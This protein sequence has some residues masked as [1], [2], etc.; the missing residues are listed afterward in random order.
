M[1]ATDRE[2]RFADCVARLV[3]DLLSRRC[4][5]PFCIRAARVVVELASR[6]G[7]DAGAIS[8]GVVAGGTDYRDWM[9]ARTGDDRT[10]DPSGLSVVVAPAPNPKPGRWGGHVVVRVGACLLVDAAVG[11]FRRDDRGI[12]LPPGLVIDFGDRH[13]FDAWLGGDPATANRTLRPPR[14]VGSAPSLITFES[15]VG[16]RGFEAYPGWMD[17]SYRSDAD[18]LASAVRDAM[19][20]RGK[21]NDEA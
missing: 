12:W 21:S 6:S 3:P 8:V 17:G 4:A 10:P 18:E 5:D 20:Q 15:R 2:R 19:Q 9:I 7:I 13:S 14:Y 16:D 1:T 11:L